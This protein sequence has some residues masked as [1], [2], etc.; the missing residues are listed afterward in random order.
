MKNYSTNPQSA[1]PPIP[2]G[3]IDETES[4]GISD[5]RELLEALESDPVI[6]VRLNSRK[7]A[8]RP[9]WES[10]EKVK[11]NEAGLYLPERPLFTLMPELHAGAF[12][13]QEAASMIAGE[14]ARRLLKSPGAVLD[15]CAAPGGKTT[16]LA[17]VLPVGSVIVANEADSQRAR[18]L[19]ENVIKW[20]FPDI[21]VTCARGEEF[22]SMREC[23]DLV[24]V[25]A[26]CSGEG[27]M[28][29][30]AVARSQWSEGL[31]RQCSLLQRE[32]LR[33]AAE[34]LKP[35]G[36]LFYST[37]TFNR[38]ENEMQAEWLRDEFGMTPVDPGFPAE[39]NIPEGIDTEMGC[40]RFLPHITRSE[41]LFF[42]VLR[43]PG[44][45]IAT[46][47]PPTATGKQF[48]C[49]GWLTD[50]H[51]YIWTEEKG[52]VSAMTPALQRLLQKLP[53]RVRVLLKGLSV[54]TAK[55]H[56]LIPTEQL[57]LSTALRR[58]AFP[59]C[60]LTETDALRY[61]RR[62]AFKLPEETPK[63]FILMTFNG[64][65]LGFM[66]NLGN[67]ANNLYPAEWRIRM[68]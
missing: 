55:G 5:S 68:K 65:P 62:E 27:M 47:F 44:T 14:A 35:G 24:N 28:R 40:F 29:K 50:P 63:G 19:A 39:W 33:A 41:G 60:A 49:S 53:R 26:P 37:C 6:S 64:F 22:A 43:K 56:D 34:A 23:F 2:Q 21:A 58:N 48:P 36:L 66:K 45:H 10:A 67:R 54:A 61:L 12:Y 59:E 15:M 8:E 16:A 25:D 13:V 9:L 17:D 42:C 51:R 57:A 46:A 32:I 4:L 31:V 52:T 20:G 11:W 3:F 38:R 1:M 30:E 7:P 18:V